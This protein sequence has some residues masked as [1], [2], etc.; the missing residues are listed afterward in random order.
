MLVKN[1]PKEI[2]SRVWINIYSQ[3]ERRNVLDHLSLDY[4]KNSLECTLSKVFDWTESN[5]GFQFWN[6]IDRRVLDE[7][8]KLYPNN[9]RKTKAEEAK[10]KE[11]LKSIE[12]EL[13]T[14]FKS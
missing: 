12:N 2:Q 7:F 9:T 4:Q 3:Y 11:E 13:F 5:E 8:Y 6:K 10:K 1:L 14:F